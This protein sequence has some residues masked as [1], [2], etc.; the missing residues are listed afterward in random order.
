M[1]DD[2]LPAVL[3]EAK[4]NVQTISFLSADQKQLLKNTMC[5][6]ASDDE[7]ELFVLIANRTG[8]DPFSKQIYLQNRWNKKLGRN[9]KTVET[10]VNGLRLI[11]ERS[12][13]YEGQEG[14]LWCGKD[15]EWKDIWLDRLPPAA[16]KVGVYKKGFRV[17]L[18]G[19][20]KFDSYVQTNKDK[21][22]TY[23]WVKMADIMI[24]KCAEALALRKAFPNE[25]KGLY[26]KEEMPLE[27]EVKIVDKSIQAPSP[28][29]S[30]IKRLFAIAH[31]NDWS[32]DRVRDFMAQRF[33]KV[34]TSDL[35]LREYNQI[36]NT[37]LQTKA[38]DNDE[39]NTPQTDDPPPAAEMWDQ[40]A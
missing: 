26:A 9:E 1:S 29:Q 37:I 32:D 11:A 4:K 39:Q 25:T 17:P 21:E 5:K 7:F 13:K 6:D 2:K 16:A 36:C 10:T 12:G 34:S 31:A 38:S 40:D 27:D 15:G 20:A 18:W 23:A 22:P 14:P 24:A 33:N 28:S 35:D 8:L 19:K 3:Q 30:Q